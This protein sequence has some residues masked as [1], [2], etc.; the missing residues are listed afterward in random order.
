[1]VR[2][3]LM[4]ILVVA[5]REVHPVETAALAV[6]AEARGV[7]AHAAVG[8]RDEELRED[9]PL[10]ERAAHRERVADHGPLRL[11][12]EMQDLAHVVEETGEH[13][14]ARLPPPPRAPGPPAGAGP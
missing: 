12:E 2:E 6:D 13:H 10:R 9:D 8:I 11:T 4:E 14:P 3:H 1:M 5:P 7:L